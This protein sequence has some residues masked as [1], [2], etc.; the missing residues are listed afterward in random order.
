MGIHAE[1]GAAHNGD[2][3]MNIL[4]VVDSLNWGGHHSARAVADLCSKQHNFTI[5]DIDGLSKMTRFNYDLVMAWL[6][7][8]EEAV[9]NVCKTHNIL[10]SSRIGGW[11]GIWRTCR[12]SPE[13]HKKIRGV[14][15][16]SPELQLSAEK[17]Y[18]RN[19]I[20]I[21][22]GVDADTFKPPKKYAH[23]GC[24]LWVGRTQDEQKD[25]GLLQRV[26]ETYKREIAV[27]AQKWSK[28]K[29]VPTNWPR[30]MVEKY[31]GA[32]GFLRTSRNEGSSNCLLE[33]MGCGLPVVAT[34]TGIAPRLL[35]PKCLATSTKHLVRAMREFDDIEYAT[36][37]GH[38]NRAKI[39][40]GWQWKF[41]RDP[42]LSF[43]ENCMG[44]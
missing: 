16:C 8:A 19:V 43:F 28:G 32:K 2:E 26:G 15:C 17:V 29:V 7:S 27:V 23:G 3:G 34:P 31:Q 18:P 42:Y 38:L 22:N 14:V 40:D 6:D 9:Y 1:T 21:M 12:V 33:A 13:I 44:E 4:L 5:T 20:T 30:E 37:I 11:K 24:W 39:V 41:R 25:Y 35:D 36:S 10:M